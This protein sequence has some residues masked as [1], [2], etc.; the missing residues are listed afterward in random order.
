MIQVSLCSLLGI[1]NS[2]TVPLDFIYLLI[3]LISFASLVY[4]FNLLVERETK[5]LILESGNNSDLTFTQEVIE[6]KSN[7]EIIPSV[8]TPYNLLVGFK[9]NIL[10]RSKIL[11]M[12]AFAFIAL[13]GASALMIEK[14]HSITKG[15]KTT[16]LNY[17]EPY[18]SNN[19]IPKNQSINFKFNNNAI[20]KIEFV[21]SIF[22][23]KEPIIKNIKYKLDTS[24]F[25]F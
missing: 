1:V 20:K 19:R 22:N 10:A 9:K 17:I 2:F 16:F 23:K 3:T 12:G 5:Q 13:G 25:T 6:D 14:N 11:G 24:R 4:L 15:I 21:S 7:L 18:N 8:Q